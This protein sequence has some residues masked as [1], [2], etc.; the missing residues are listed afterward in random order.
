M[1]RCRGVLVEIIS[2]T[3]LT[4]VSDKR[5]LPFLHQDSSPMNRRASRKRLLNFV[6]P[7]AQTIASRM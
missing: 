1:A 4:D 7:G 6:T 2:S 3:Q 5:F